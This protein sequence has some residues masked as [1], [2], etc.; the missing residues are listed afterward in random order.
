MRFID[1]SIVDLPPGWEVR[2]GLATQALINGDIEA[3]DRANIWQDLKNSLADIS[4][5][6]CWYCETGIP[7]TDNAVD[8]FRP[9][10]RVRGV[11]L[12]GDGESLENYQ[13]QPEHLG[14][15]WAAY[16][17]ENFRFSCQHCNEF[18]KNLRGT[19]GG[20]ASYFPLV[21]EQHRAYDLI[22]QDNE[23]PALLDPCD[24]LDWR[25]LSY[26]KAGKPFSHFN[27]GSED[28]LRVKLSIRIYHLDQASVNASRAAQWAQVK[29]IFEDT[30]K[31][32]LKKLRGDVGAD[33]C[34][35]RELKKLRQ[36]FNPKNKSTY[37]GFLVYQ[38]EQ[39]QLLDSESLHG[40]IGEILR[41]LG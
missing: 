15:K 20:K 21:N 30:K 27:S 16:H 14:Y 12:S 23:S 1:N 40:W 29:P 39:E 9:K 17:I 5:D 32:F 6:R 31:W 10:G 8:H 13:I 35:R 41:G 3:D 24:V 4:S 2:A 19:A 36:W 34:F 11:R 18:R 7:R 33:A 37:L 38:L 26:D 22:D 25:M 28:D